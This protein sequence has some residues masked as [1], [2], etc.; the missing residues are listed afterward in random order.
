MHLHQAQNYSISK[1][2]EQLKREKITFKKISLLLCCRNVMS[3]LTASLR[4]QT[5]PIKPMSVSLQR[6]A[7]QQF[8][9]RM[10]VTV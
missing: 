9:Q 10:T 7:I 6:T 8:D 5:E 1:S 4:L 2:G 3:I